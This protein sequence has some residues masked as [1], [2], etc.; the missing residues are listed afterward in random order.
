VGERL[1][2]AYQVADDI[3]DALADEA[4]LGKP[5][6]RDAA[7]ARPSAVRELGL[8]GAVLRLREVAEQA[9][10]AIPAC[11]GAHDLAGLIRLQARRLVPK[12]LAAQAA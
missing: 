8:G 12:S 3:G 10:A 11:G 7:L 2:E 6:G 5:V 4:E 9:V 1:G